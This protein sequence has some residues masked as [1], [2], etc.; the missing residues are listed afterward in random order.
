MLTN[1]DSSLKSYLKDVLAELIEMPLFGRL[2][3]QTKLVQELMAQKGPCCKACAVFFLA[4]FSSFDSA[5]IL[6]TKSLELCQNGP[7]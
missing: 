2:N 1:K 4:G 6:L 7:S 5:Y 3:T